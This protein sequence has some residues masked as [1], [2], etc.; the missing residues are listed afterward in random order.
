MSAILPGP[1]APAGSEPEYQGK[2]AFIDREYSWLEFNQRV[3]EEAQDPA[4]PLME[5]IQFLSIVA[6]NL[7]EFI[8]VRVAGLLQKVESVL[9]V[10]GI[11]GLDAAVKLDTILRL[12]QKSVKQQYKCWNEDLL[13]KLRENNVHIKTMA[14]LG[15]DEEKY[16]HTYFRK[17]IYPLLTPIR[18]DPAHPFPWVSNKALCLA[19]LLKED[20]R[21]DGLGVV[22]IPRS[23]ARLISVPNREKGYSFIFIQDLVQHFITDLFKGYAIKS[24]APFRATRNSNLYQEDEEGSSLI[25]AVEAVVHN[26]RRGDVVRLE[27]DKNASKRIVDALT[28]TFDVDAKQVFRVDGPVNLNRLASLYNMVPLSQL[29][30]PPI[31]PSN[32]AHFQDSEDLFHEIRQRDIMLHH[33]FDS[34]DP[35]VRFIQSAAEDPK[36][37][38]IKQTLY[39][40]NEESPIMYALLE[41]AEQGKEVVAVVEL[42]ARFDEKS[43]I[44]WA[45]QLEE[46]GGTVV[47]GLVGLKTHCKLSLA[48][49]KEDSGF[50]Q[51]A[52]VGTGNYNPETARRYTDISFLTSDPEITEGVSEVFNFLTSQSRSPDFKTLMVGPVNFLGETLRRIRAETESALAGKRSGI[53]AKMNSLL[54]KE[55]IEALYEASRAGVPVRL[56]VRGICALRPGAKQ[57]S[58]NIQ[59]KSVVGR[60]LEHSRIFY[61]ENDGNPS[62]F[63]GS[64]DWMDRN[65]RERVEVAIPIKDANFIRQ[66]ED[67]LTVYWADNA[68]SRL[69]RAD[70]SYVRSAPPAGEA[71]VNAQEWLAKRAEVPDLPLPPAPRL[72]PVRAPLPEPEPIET[73][74]T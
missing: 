69:M 52:H 14:S 19:A 3:L 34:Y 56:I 36:V 45:R 41:A 5:R 8:E 18:V 60:F 7:D 63:V 71:P 55:V 16:V 38:V 49:R 66:I 26:R 27:I 13:P 30:F 1:P 43:N 20:K 32:T 39:R 74:Q 40:T 57:L 73:L 47:Y 61:F 53:T 33:P 51:Y 67:I 9:P 23:L 42:K 59:V 70:G 35:V 17:E 46:K 44:S 58:E 22:T 21:R 62:V 2:N 24:C 64:G 6:N 65:L 29:K 15:K 72:F 12:I 31:H 37:Q 54:D 4:N 68:K 50:A 48:I 11:A 10:D 25:D 28:R